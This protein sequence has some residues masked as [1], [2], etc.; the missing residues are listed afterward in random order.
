[1][2]L[3]YPLAFGIGILS[4]N[5]PDIGILVCGVLVVGILAVAFYLDT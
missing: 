5:I 1:M 2:I 3:L 4:G